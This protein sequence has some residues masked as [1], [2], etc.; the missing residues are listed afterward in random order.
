VLEDRQTESGGAVVNYRAAID[1]GAPENATTLL[2]V[3]GWASTA[4]AWHAQLEGEP[5]E[6]LGRNRRLLAVDLPGHGASEVLPEGAEHSLDALADAL[7]AVLDRE[8]TERAVL[9]GHSNGTPVTMRF[10]RRFPER[11]LGLVAVDGQVVDLGTGEMI[12][13]FVEQ[14]RSERYQDAVEGMVR[15]MA[16]ETFADPIRDGLITMAA[17]VSQRA[18]IETLVSAADPAGWSDAPVT[19]PLLLVLA[20]QPT[21]DEAYQERVNAM[22]EDA[23]WLIWPETNHFLQIQQPLEFSRAVN[24]WLLDHGL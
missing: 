17:S 8:G 22:A 2:L 6:T 18:L 24:A 21:W 10:L 14:L 20:E 4:W 23:T 5:L 12:A 16:G 3:H 13:P 1:P 19:A 7:A 15:G 9:V 11:V